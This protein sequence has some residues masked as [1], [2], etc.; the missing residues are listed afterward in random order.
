MLITS[1]GSQ[2]NP[3]TGYP[4]P[5]TLEVE[6]T[7]VFKTGMYEYDNQYVYWTWRPRR[8]SPAWT[9]R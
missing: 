8:S 4:V 7:G 1:V 9:R 6:V 3:V 5:R 2:V